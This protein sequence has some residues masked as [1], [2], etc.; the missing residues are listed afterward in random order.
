MIIN[1]I[2]NTTKNEGKKIEMTLLYKLSL[3]GD[4]ASTFHSCCDN[5]GN[6]LTLVRNS[7]GYRCGGFTTKNWNV[8]GYGNINDQ[9]AF[10]FSLEYKEQYFTY[11]GYNAISNNRDCG[12]IFGSAP[13]LL[14]SN[15]CSKNCTSV[16]N[17]PVDY[18]GNKLRCLSGGWK[19]F[20][21]DEMEV[22]KID[23]L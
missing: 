3:H 10:L 20:K 2:L 7:K 15:I 4:N 6:T 16:C 11:D 5:K 18:S 12:P 13:D 8:D 17:F 21:V 23:I 22:Y 14:I 1:W 9:N 19:F